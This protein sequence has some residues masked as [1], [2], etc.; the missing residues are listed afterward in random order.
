MS[1]DETSPSYSPPLE[2]TTTARDAHH[3]DI[4]YAAPTGRSRWLGGPEVTIGR[5]ISPVLASLQSSYSSDSDESSD[6]ILHKQK[7]A[8]ASAAIQYRTCSW[9]K[10]CSCYS[11]LGHYMYL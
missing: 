7:E 10:V 4:E 3:L 1:K 6:A 2:K 11:C 8:E 5:R 9:Q